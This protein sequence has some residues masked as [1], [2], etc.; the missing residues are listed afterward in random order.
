VWST[1]ARR[2]ARDFDEDDLYAAMDQLTGRWVGWEKQLY[3]QSF[4]QGVSLVL[5]ELT[6]VSFEGE[7]PAGL[8]RC[9]HSRDHRCDRPQAI[10]AVATDAIQAETLWNG[11]YLLGTNTT[12][13][14]VPASGLPRGLRGPS[15]G[16]GCAA[17]SRS[18]FR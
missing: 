8:S 5:Y 7:G 3:K 10:L 9:G 16:T 11:L 12:A 15:A 13:Q 4:P 1:Q 18:C 17:R 2:R 6:S 14:E